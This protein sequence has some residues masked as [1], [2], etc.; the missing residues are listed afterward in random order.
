MA[1]ALKKM[2]HELLGREPGIGAHQDT[3]PLVIQIPSGPN[4]QRLQCDRTE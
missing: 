2:I 3:V 4:A 1:V